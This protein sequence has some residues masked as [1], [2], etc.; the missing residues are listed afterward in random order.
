M[1][2]ALKVLTIV[3]MMVT[4]F[5]GCTSLSNYAGIDTDIINNKKESMPVFFPD[6]LKVKKVN[7]IDLDNYRICK[8]GIIYKN[9]DNMYGIM[10]LDGNNDT[11]AIYTY[12]EE[13]NIYFIVSKSTFDSD[14]SID[15]MNCF[16]IVDVNGK[17][18]VLNEYC[19]FDVLNSR[20][21]KAIK[22]TESTEEKDEAL[23]YSSENQFSIMPSDGDTLYKGIWYI[24]DTSTGKLVPDATGTKPYVIGT[25]GNYI[26]YTNDNEQ[27]VVVNGN[28]EN[29]PS[30]AD[31][32]DDGSYVI[33]IDDKGII[34]DTEGNKLFDFDL[35]TYD[36]SSVSGE[37]YIFHKY[38]ENKQRYIYSVFDK[39]GTKV[40]VYFDSLIYIYGKFVFCDNELYDFDGNKVLNGK[41]DSVYPDD[42]TQNAFMLKNENNIIVINSNGKIIYNQANSEDIHFDS[43]YFT[44]DSKI[45]GERYCYSIKDSDFKFKGDD[46]SYW[47]VKIENNEGNYDVIDTISGDVIVANYTSY[48]CSKLN[49]NSYYLYAKNESGTVDIYLISI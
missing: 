24:Y 26:T 16:G 13:E 33:P 12:C 38:D 37:Y 22:A 6:K 8:G 29:L 41:F 36:V 11:G 28:G 10:S 23:I 31:L 27:Q 46:I 44:S 48:K 32:L 14:E 9:S 30:G 3:L 4:I 35:E 47:I 15:K 2:K 40:S 49:N 21:I 1:K 42:F 18:L 20:Y 39:K 19:S 5:S 7:S 34:Y 45:N 43:T 17:Q 25:R